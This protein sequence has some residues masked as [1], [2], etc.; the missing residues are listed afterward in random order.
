[1]A[2]ESDASFGAIINKQP[3]GRCGEELRECYGRPSYE[4]HMADRNEGG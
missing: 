4:G 3:V 2:D 1:M